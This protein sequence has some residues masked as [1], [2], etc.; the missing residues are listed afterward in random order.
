MDSIKAIEMSTKKYTITIAGTAI[1]LG[2]VAFYGIPVGSGDVHSSMYFF[3]TDELIDR[4]DLIVIATVNKDVITASPSD[5]YP[6]VQLTTL[7]NL[8]ILK[9]RA[10]VQGEKPLGDEKSVEIRSMGNGIV[11]KNGLRYDVTSYQTPTFT[12]GERVLLFLEYDKGHDLGD[13]YYPLN[14][15]VG[16]YLIDGDMANNVEPDRVVKVSEM[17]ER[18]MDSLN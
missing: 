12:V 16:K 17:K 8:E 11:V 15:V 4:A 3:D 7:G 6:G 1:L 10:G 2:F 13:G 5:T 9:D 14:G 18:I